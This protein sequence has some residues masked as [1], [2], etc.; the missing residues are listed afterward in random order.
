MTTDKNRLKLPPPRVLDTH[1]PTGIKLYGYNAADMR[2]A[3]EASREVKS[4]TDEQIDS[5]WLSLP[6]KDGFW[7]M[8]A[9]AIERKCAE[10]WGV[11]LEGQG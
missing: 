4:L 7:L 11:K 2:A 3:L 8:F 9:R 10:A 5:I 6:M 1:L